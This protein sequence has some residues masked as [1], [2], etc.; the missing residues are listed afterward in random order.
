M[1]DLGS[2]PIPSPFSIHK[3]HRVESR[4]GNGGMASKSS[5]S[6]PRQN[7]EDAEPS[8]KRQYY[9]RMDQ[10][11]IELCNL[12]LRFRYSRFLCSLWRPCW[13]L[14]LLWDFTNTHYRFTEAFIFTTVQSDIYNWW[15][16]GIAVN[17]TKNGTAF[18]Q[19]PIRNCLF[20]GTSDLTIVALYKPAQKMRQSL[21]Y[22]LA[23]MV[24]GA[25]NAVP[26]W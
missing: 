26:C 12:C 13:W 19:C 25:G 22:T 23:E 18:L 6:L 8:A 17:Q 1:V 5:S 24:C 11:C 7:C 20:Q 4:T 16:Y 10:D 3:N 2:G 15:N 14:S 21:E 9:I